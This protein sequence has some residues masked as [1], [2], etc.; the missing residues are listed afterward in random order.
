MRTISP[1]FLLQL[2]QNIIIPS[3]LKTPFLLSPT[4]PSQ[5]NKKHTNKDTETV[6][7]IILRLGMPDLFP[8]LW[9]KWPSFVSQPFV[10]DFK[11]G[12]A[13]HSLV[14][15]YDGRQVLEFSFC[16]VFQKKKICRKAHLAF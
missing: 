8:N 13:C 10:C 6:S 16:I 11:E 12:F 14:L 3:K 15:S 5:H 7:F 1:L 9:L 2:S 4:L